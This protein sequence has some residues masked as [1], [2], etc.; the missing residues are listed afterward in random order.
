MTPFAQILATLKDI[1]S[2]LAMAVS[3]QRSEDKVP[4]NH[5]SHRAFLDKFRESSK[6]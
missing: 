6:Y 4:N 5:G 2:S 3:M 1:R